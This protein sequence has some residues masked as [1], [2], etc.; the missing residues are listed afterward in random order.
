MLPNIPGYASAASGLLL[1]SMTGLAGMAGAMGMGALAG[2]GWYGPP[3]C[4]DSCCPPCPCSVQCWQVAVSGVVND[5]CVDC[6][7]YNKTWY[8]RRPILEIEQWQCSIIEG[9]CSPCG[10]SVLTLT[11]DENYLM[12]LNFLGSVWTKTARNCNQSLAMDFV[13]SGSDCDFSAASITITPG[14]DANGLCPCSSCGQPCGSPGT[15]WYEGTE[16]SVIPVTVDGVTNGT[17]S[18]CDFFNQTYNLAQS[19]SSPCGF[20]VV[21]SLAGGCSYFPPYRTVLAVGLALNVSNIGC[22]EN[23]V[24]ASLQFV[25]GGSDPDI[26]FAKYEGCSTS[27]PVDGTNMGIVLTRKYGFLYDNACDWPGTITI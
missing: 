11:R 8:L 22:G 9:Q 2:V 1:P 27:K 7:D 16:P 20:G 21:I 6:D 12:T 19:L 4:A 26:I 15:I 10:D 25:L 13:S 18:S 24:G 14:T 5:S 17:C 23:E 3:D